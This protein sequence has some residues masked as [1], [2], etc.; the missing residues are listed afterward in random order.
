MQGFPVQ[1]SACYQT[2]NNTLPEASG[3][4]KGVSALPNASVDTRP[5]WVREC[6]VPFFFP[7][8]AVYGGIYLN[9]S[10]IR[11]SPSSIV[12]PSGTLLGN[13]SNTI[14]QQGKSVT[15]EL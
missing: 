12:Y 9:N 10:I 14:L 5:S 11:G 4:D 6:T 8:P 15:V 3:Y 13:S 1:R 7:G 2:E